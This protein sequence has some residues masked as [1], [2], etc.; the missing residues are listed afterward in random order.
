MKIK[1]NELRALGKSQLESK[2]IELRKDLIKLNSQIAAGTVPENP[3][4]VR[5]IKKTIAR[6]FTIIKEKEGLEKKQ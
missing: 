1:N 5:N 6:V 4:N 2:L 3:G